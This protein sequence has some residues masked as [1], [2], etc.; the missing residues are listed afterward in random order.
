MSEQIGW[1]FFVL[2]AF[3]AAID[4]TRR[5]FKRKHRLA[6]CCGQP[7]SEWFI[8]RDDHGWGM[9]CW[10]CKHISPYVTRAEFRS[11][12]GGR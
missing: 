10:H 2:L 3:M 5:Q 9:Q 11:A 12:G 1:I 6:Q 8:N 7:L 4:A